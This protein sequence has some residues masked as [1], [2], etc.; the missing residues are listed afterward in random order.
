[1]WALGAPLPA[2]EGYPWSPSLQLR[3]INSGV[4]LFQ[5]RRAVPPRHTSG[6][7]RGPFMP[8][9]ILHPSLKPFIPLFAMHF[10]RTDIQSM[11]CHSATH[12]CK[13]NGRVTWGGCI[14]H[15]IVKHKSQRTPVATTARS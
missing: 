10:C 12:A 3:L 11:C 4:W 9:S 6:T 13:T 15:A 8:G 14:R 1:M 7:I 5:V 2:P